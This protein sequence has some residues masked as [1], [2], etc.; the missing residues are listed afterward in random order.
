MYSDSTSGIE[1]LVGDFIGVFGFDEPD[2]RYEGPS[3]S[4][5]EEDTVWYVLVRNYADSSRNNISDD[6]KPFGTFL[7]RW[8]TN[9]GDTMFYRETI[10][11]FCGELDYPVFDRYPCQFRD[12][13]DR[14]FP[15]QI[16]FEDIIE[17]TNLL[18]SD[19]VD[20]YAYA[21][22]DEVFAVDSSGLLR[23]YEF[24]NV[25]SHTDTLSITCI[26]SVLLPQPLRDDPVWASSDF[27][28]A[29]VGDRSTGSHRLNG[30]VVFFDADDP[31]KNMAVFHDGDSII[32]LEDS[33]H[34]PDYATE[35]T[36]VCIGEYNYPEHHPTPAA[37]R[38]S[39][40]SRGELRI[41]VCYQAV[42][43]EVIVD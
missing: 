19:S 18:P 41:L 2:A 12:P 32:F 6:I 37:R 33:I 40:I 1:S 38:G 43:Q 36:S 23:I 27:R 14:T 29:D 39:V 8:K 34:L 16:Q 4:A 3:W 7:D 13:E 31:D 28:S 5:C 22:Q 10:P 9:D 42:D 24:V 20:Y 30:A 21:D 26:D 11:L 17:A 25:T 15:D 35:I